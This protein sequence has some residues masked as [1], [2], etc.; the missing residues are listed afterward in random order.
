MFSLILT[1]GVVCLIVGGVILFASEGDD[2]LKTFV[3][4]IIFLLI[5]IIG[6][7]SSNSPHTQKEKESAV[8]S[9]QVQIPKD[10]IYSVRFIISWKDANE[11]KCGSNV[12]LKGKTEKGVGDTLTINLN[13]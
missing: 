1:I 8:D 11:I 2:G 12:I 3:F 5:G 4:G 10:S 13:P 7:C 6:K 9:T